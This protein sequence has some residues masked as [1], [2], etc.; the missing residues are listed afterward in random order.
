MRKFALTAF[1]IL[2][3]VLVVSVSVERFNEWATQEAPGH[4]HFAADQQFPSIGK[5][6]NS[7][8]YD[9][10]RRIVE[11]PF[12]IESPR[13]CIDIS[14][15]SVRNTPPPCFEYQAGWNGWTVSLRSPPFHI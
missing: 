3:G 12:V 5:A 11:R 6:E 10:Y 13:E 2:Y 1:A 14:V 8:T 4:G 15:V 9:R 7:Q